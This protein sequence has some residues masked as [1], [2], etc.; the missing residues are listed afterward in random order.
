MGVIENGMILG[1]SAEY[2]AACAYG[3]RLESLIES[4]TD[5]FMSEASSVEEA[6]GNQADVILAAVKALRATGDSAA[7]LRSFDHAIRSN[8]YNLARDCAERAL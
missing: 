2:D 6:I 7:F 3:E 5:D 1:A 8:F 4:Y